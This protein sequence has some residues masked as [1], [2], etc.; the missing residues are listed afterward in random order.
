MRKTRK[1]MKRIVSVLLAI[2]M[3]ITSISYTPEMVSAAELKSGN[4]TYTIGNASGNIEGFVAQ[5][6]FEE[7]RFGF[8]W[9][10][11][12]CQVEIKQQ[13]RQVAN[14]G[15]KNNGDSIY[16]TE[17]DPLGLDKGEYTIVF[18]Q[19]DTAVETVPLTVS[20]DEVVTTTAGAEEPI[21]KPA[22]V[23][24]RNYAKY[25]GKYVFKFDEVEG[26]TAYNVY[27]D[28]KEESV[29]SISGSGD[30]ITADELGSAELTPGDH[31]FYLTAVLTEA[32][33]DKSEAIPFTYSADV[34]DN[35]EIAQVYIQTDDLT[36]DAK[37]FE[38][39]QGK[40]NSAITIVDKKGGANPDIYED[41][42]K[43]TIKVRGNSTANAQ[44]KAF[45]ISFTDKRNVFGFGDA[46]KWCLLAN[47]FD[48]T[49][50]R[51]KLAMDFAYDVLGLTNTGRSQYI[52]LYLN[53]VYMGNYL[54]IEAV[55]AGSTRVDIQSESVNSNDILIE[56]EGLGPNGNGKV[57]EGV[58]YIT[59]N[60]VT[61]EGSQ[62]HFNIGSPENGDGKDGSGVDGEMTEE[63]LA[64]KDNH[65][66]EFLN[67]FEQDLAKDDYAAYSQYI[68][69]KSFVDFYIVN[70]LFKNKDFS[71]SSTRFYIKDDKLYAGPLWDLDL[72]SGNVGE[73]G[74]AKA[75]EVPLY[76]QDMPWFKA[77]MNNE[78]FANAV[79][80]RFEE[81][82]PQ[83]IALYEG[84]SNKIDAL[85]GTNGEIIKSVKRNY[86]SVEE[87]GAGW[88]DTEPDQSDAYSNANS[89]KNFDASVAYLKT[90]LGE[91]VEHLTRLWGEDTVLPDYSEV[92]VPDDGWTSFGTDENGNTWYYA[93]SYY[94]G[95]GHHYLEN[96]PGERGYGADIT[97][98]EKTVA[99]GFIPATT[100][101]SFWV[102]K[103]H[104]QDKSET[105]FHST[106][107]PDVIFFA[108]SLFKP[109]EITYITVR[110]QDGVDHFLPIKIEKAKAPA[111]TADVTQ[112]WTK[113]SVKENAE[114]PYDY[115]INTAFW[116]TSGVNQGISDI[117]VPHTKTNYHKSGCQFEAD[118][119]A[120]V[121]YLE[122]TP[123]P[124]AWINADRYLSGSKDYHQQ[125]D[126]YEFNLDLFT[127][128][129]HYVSLIH[130]N[131]NQKYDFAIKVVEKGTD[132]SEGAKEIVPMTED[133]IAA[134]PKVSG[135]V[136]WGTKVEGSDI[137]V[138]DPDSVRASGS[139]DAGMGTIRC[140]LS[141]SVIKGNLTKVVIDDV[142]ITE[143]GGTITGASREFH[144]NAALLSKEGIYKV[145]VTDDSGNTGTFYY[146]SEKSI[147]YAISSVAATE[148]TAES[149]VISWIPSEDLAASECTYTVIIDGTTVTE[150]S[151]TTPSYTWTP[152]GGLKEKEEHTVII[153]AFKD[154]DQLA[155][156]EE[157]PYKFK[158][159]NEPTDVDLEVKD[160]DVKYDPEPGSQATIKFSIHNNGKTI[161]NFN[162]A[163]IVLKFYEKLTW[164]DIDSVTNW[165]EGDGWQFAN[166][167]TV[168]GLAEDGSF[169]YDKDITITYNR[170]TTTKFYEA[171]AIRFGIS[172]E[173]F[174]AG[175]DKNRDNNYYVWYAVQPVPNPENVTLTSKNNNKSLEV[176]WEEPA[177]ADTNGPYKYNV[178]L[179]G[180][181]SPA[182]DAPIEGTTYT[183]TQ[184]NAFEG[185][186]NVTVKTVKD[187]DGDQVESKGTT[188]SIFVYSV[189]E[190]KWHA[191]DNGTGSGDNMD[192]ETGAHCKDV[193][194]N[195]WY[196]YNGYGTELNPEE[197]D[198]TSD[199]G[200]RSDQWAGLH[201]NSDRMDVPSVELL[202]KTWRAWNKV[203]INGTTYTADNKE[204]IVGLNGNE[205][206]NIAQSLFKL[207]AG[208]KSKVFEITV[209]DGSQDV[210]ILIKVAAP[211]DIP[212]V[213]SLRAIASDTGKDIT[214][215]WNRYDNENPGDYT[216]EISVDGTVKATTQAE[217]NER[218]NRML[219]N[220]TDVE[221]GRHLIEVRRGQDSDYSS[222]VSTYLVVYDESTLEWSQ[223]ADNRTQDV[224]NDTWWYAKNFLQGNHLLLDENYGPQITTDGKYF[225][226]VLKKDGLTG[227]PSLD[228]ATEVTVDG[229]TYEIGTEAGDEVLAYRDGDQI[230]LSHKLFPVDDETT[231]E[232]IF[233]ITVTG[234]MGA[235]HAVETFLVKL[236]NEDYSSP[237]VSLKYVDKEG[238][239]TQEKDG[240]VV[241]TWKDPEDVAEYGYKLHYYDY[242]DPYDP[243]NPEG[244]KETV[245]WI[246]NGDY[247][248]NEDGSMS[249]H[250]TENGVNLR[251][252]TEIRVVPVISNSGVE[253]RDDLG[254]AVGQAELT[255]YGE[256]TT[257]TGAYVSDTEKSTIVF[258]VIN[259]GTAAVD[260][261]A[262]YQQEHP[263]EKHILEI[264]ITEYTNGDRE[265][266]T[267]GTPDHAN[268]FMFRY[269]FEDDSFLPGE[270]IEAT[271]DH[272]FKDRNTYYF[273][274]EID[275]N[276][277]IYETNQ[278]NEGLNGNSQNFEL[279]AR[280]RGN[281]K[282]EWDEESNS[283]VAYFQPDVS[284]WSAGTSGMGEGV[285][286]FEFSYYDHGELKTC[287]ISNSGITPLEGHEWGDHVYKVTL[288][289]DG[290]NAVKHIDSDTI[291]TIATVGLD[292]TT[293]AVFA[294]DTPF[295]QET[296]M[297][298]T[299]IPGGED[300]GPFDF[301]IR[302]GKV[303]IEYKV[304]YASDYYNNYHYRNIAS[305]GNGYGGTWNT[306]SVVNSDYI[307]HTETDLEHGE[308][309]VTALR[310]AQVTRDYCE[311][312]G[313]S[314]FEPNYQVQVPEGTTVK[315]GD[316]F[317]KNTGQVS[318]IVYNGSAI[319]FNYDNCGLGKYYA[320][321]I[322]G[323]DGQQLI[324]ACRIISTEDEQDWFPINPAIGQPLS[325]FY[326][327]TVEEGN[328]ESNVGG[329]Y[330]YDVSD[331]DLSAISSYNSTHISITTDNEKKLNVDEE[332][333][334][335]KW[336]ILVAETKADAQGRAIEPENEDD[337]KVYWGYPAGH[338]GAIAA[339][340]G[341]NINFAM[342]DMIKD[343][344][345]HTGK[346][347]RQNFYYYMRIYTDTE[348]APEDYISA[349]IRIRANIPEIDILPEENIKDV[350]SD[351]DSLSVTFTPTER[352]AKGKYV[353]DIY[354]GDELI[355]EATDLGP[356]AGEDITV[357]LPVPADQQEKLDQDGSE[358]KIKI[359]S[360]WCYEADN[361]DTDHWYDD[362][363]GLTNHYQS[364]ETTYTYINKIVAGEV[365]VQ[366]FQ[367]NT[368][369]EAG[370]VSEYMPSMRVVSSVGKAILDAS[371]KRHT[372]TSYGTLIAYEKEGSSLTKEDMVKD[373]ASQYVTDVPAATRLSKWGDDKDN[374]YYAVNLKQINYNFDML[375]FD[376]CYRAYAVLDDGTV[377]YS[378]NIYKVNTYEIA[379]NLYENKHMYTKEGHDF[380][381]N[382]ILNIVS[383]RENAADIG[384]AMTTT[385][386]VANNEDDKYDTINK[387]YK[388]IIYYALTGKGYTY[389]NREATF[390]SKTL[391]EEKEAELLGWLKEATSSSETTLHE[392]IEK[393][394]DTIDQ[395]DAPGTK[396]KGF[397][398]KVDYQWDNNLYK[399]YGTKK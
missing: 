201:N 255:F 50:V 344:P 161:D 262:M 135:E 38:K 33:T 363:S 73:E 230:Y 304:L 290:E 89:R 298:W 147:V 170:A 343:F 98:T 341:D 31:K 94:Q 190:G 348:N 85:I 398:K 82:K 194:G 110:G 126:C 14:L 349:P 70:E 232:R 107:A 250:L 360:K 136:D 362:G 141:D 83:A 317:I 196:Y 274:A 256:P 264:Q 320:L 387:A 221:E 189:D 394:V 153:K 279:A 358:F 366:G 122:N 32:E 154:G 156:T 3:V 331:W 128:G 143:V 114:V 22:N 266:L 12:S 40:F 15:T 1:T 175:N 63:E 338:E 211:S 342:S 376:Y 383:M 278:D 325:D 225:R 91:R 397:Y 307:S 64:A 301:N 235:D 52:D 345:G 182:N 183:I 198:F 270:T 253:A 220:L 71:Y 231:R 88:S 259:V 244:N 113:L 332:D 282:I 205:R 227:G 167:S 7:I 134:D 208:E 311:N 305:A 90:W 104:L 381:Y 67:K 291:V 43:T 335:Q 386:N 296:E 129:T 103:T 218:G 152:E 23:L 277:Y 303:N 352:G 6:A 371:G 53:G 46:K 236:V 119:N 222:K 241:F 321:Q 263:A 280:Y 174:I 286:A 17:L 105:F 168:E 60:G 374:Y 155:S 177:D 229:T 364:T 391:G 369:K 8:A 59:T 254:M 99:F 87:G 219:V 34:G 275:P 74:L 313:T 80:E 355:T 193:Y 187:E 45:N 123:V 109:G 243:N 327:H 77:L 323:P 200:K 261:K 144:L 252:N 56:L 133:E 389:Q 172:W 192:D 55:E 4:T 388:D 268:P 16:L 76:C 184:D 294:D 188:A 24:V 78:T 2:A 271:H 68:D 159:S 120:L 51:N 81:I 258:T 42:A 367:I 151:L 249:Y 312:Y 86:A 322:D 295:F 234:S 47:A 130:Q 72:S 171:E 247:K 54:L 314:S 30:Y 285:S 337:Y 384:H 354:L 65:A 10:G 395:K 41:M 142:D 281:L 237:N 378:D 139:Y 399:D 57:E 195:I 239:E 204:A 96:Y 265:E 125:D 361:S 69:M 216:Y 318:P 163:N 380:L 5:G 35:T 329:T 319:N 385:L 28:E 11:T 257:K 293:T 246:R 292:G 149:A 165:F 370:G 117:C 97:I 21:T 379:E 203:T 302:A 166:N 336:K 276:N 36:K 118:T 284:Q 20:K 176:K 79:A 132:P 162:E 224:D 238:N 19:S 111:H 158:Y 242:T 66:L 131:G 299:P 346:A 100:A 392:W 191:W 316:D 202:F 116:N 102:N 145:T 309:H 173:G 347:G 84:D 178:Y 121:L 25:T 396:Y 127:L 160:V 260:T 228:P 272:L 248:V 29:A 267:P 92:S 334:H 106:A 306:M 180:S 9:A 18:T 44:K 101:S 137:Y 210:F 330:Y 308:Y 339:R 372:V 350:T 179:N 49:M 37:S 333:G 289:K 217:T 324:L 251:S 169:P 27:V 273:T 328:T 269:N 75:N 297:D 26:A 148:V 140:T 199:L 283:Y 206:L 393:H 233:P 164:D 353:Y 315:A 95:S 181:E 212:P 375:K 368:N 62:V 226:F 310:F 213:E 351:S 214:V 223:W 150:N 207:G 112:G 39:D 356:S 209:S 93:T 185:T 288:P 373:S 245:K 390:T 340:D 108:Q 48:K 146:K 240:H 197:S 287:R 13:D 377:V 124:T 61:G 357:S 300:G 365:K 186:Q 382:E 115:Y 326:Y 359:V 58:R 138:Y 157:E 215:G